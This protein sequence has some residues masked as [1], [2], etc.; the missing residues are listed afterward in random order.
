M[1]RSFEKEVDDSDED[2]WAYTSQKRQKQN[3]SERE[4]SS[5]KAAPKQPIIA[6]SGEVKARRPSRR[7]S[8]K[9]TKVSTAT[10]RPKCQTSK[11]NLIGSS[12]KGDQDALQECGCPMTTVPR[13][14]SESRPTFGKDSKFVGSEGAICDDSSCP[15]CQ[16][17]FR[18]LAVAESP[19]WHVMDCMKRTLVTRQGAVRLVEACLLRMPHLDFDYEV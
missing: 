8:P 17:P 5:L 16:M 2:I 11:T 13:R 6:R 1:K 18:S 3:P 7:R 19:R 15:S 12:H 9:L 10:S 4:K 14:S